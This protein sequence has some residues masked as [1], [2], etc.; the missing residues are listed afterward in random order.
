VCN[1]STIHVCDLCKSAYYCSS[2][3]LWAD[4][5][6]PTLLCAA[7]SQFDVLSRPTDEH[8]RAI[9]FPVDSTIPR[10][11]WLRCEWRKDVGRRYQYAKFESLLGSEALLS[12]ISIRYNSV[13]KRELLDTIYVCHREAFLFDGSGPN[14]SIAS[15]TTPI[16]D[17]FMIG[18]V[19]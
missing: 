4:W 1:K 14:K 19:Q 8:V 12:Q 7:F 18:E 2:T 17:N 6:T 16:L 13:L 3:C 10:F 11:I 9:F 5:P 15:I